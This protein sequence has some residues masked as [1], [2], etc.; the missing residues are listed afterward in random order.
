MKQVLTSLHPD[1]L[2]DVLAHDKSQ[3]LQQMAGIAGFVGVTRETMQRGGVEFVNCEIGQV[4]LL[5]RARR[6]M[7]FRRIH[8]YSY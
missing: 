1:F 7:L 5:G 4:E 6:R 3:L 2:Q 8:Y